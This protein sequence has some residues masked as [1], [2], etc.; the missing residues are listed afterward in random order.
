M[1][2]GA[3]ETLLRKLEQRDRLDE[4][5]RV[6]LAE[7]AGEELQFTAGTDI[8]SEGDRPNRSILL[9]AG[10]AIRYRVL[11][12]GQRQITA[13]HVPGDFVDLHSFPLKHMDHSVGALSDCRIVTFPHE[14]LQHITEAWPHLTRMLWLMTLIDAAMHREWLVAMGRRNALE[15]MAHLLCELYVRLGIAGLVTDDAF[16]F[17]ITQTELGDA[18]G[19]SAVYVNR[20]LQQLRGEGLITWQ[21]QMVRVLDW[22]RLQRIAEFD[23]GYLHLE[24][25]PR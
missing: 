1:Q 7:S 11:R 4:A 23:P 8:V 24:R 13:I 9:V 16:V 20:V 19:L 22:P 3:I 14:K 17:P 21:G 18:L 12:D 25:E 5:E 2:L 6:V 10:L 15:Q